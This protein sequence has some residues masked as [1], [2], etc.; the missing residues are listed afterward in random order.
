MR[1]AALVA[2]LTLPA[3]AEAGGLPKGATYI[4]QLTGSQYASG[5]GEYIVPP[6][7]RA[8]SRTGMKS[9]VAGADFAATLQSESDVGA[10]YDVQGEEVWLYTLTVTAGLTP[11]EID[12]EPEGV[13]SPWFS[14]SARILTEDADRLDEFNCLVALATQELAKR[15]RP[16]GQVLIDGRFCN[17]KE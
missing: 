5:L 7:A 13:V 15:Y 1:A 4:I 17:R 11:A 12:V 8:L 10:W 6:F 14:V 16:K 2:L 3:A 9:K